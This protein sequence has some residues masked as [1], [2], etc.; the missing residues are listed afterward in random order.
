MGIDWGIIFQQFFSQAIG[1]NAMVFAMAAIGLNIHFGYA[2]LL[3]FGHV[4]FMAAGAL[5]LIHI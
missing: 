1:I 4:G 3:N 5:S 2:G